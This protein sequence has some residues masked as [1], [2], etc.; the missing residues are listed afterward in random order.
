MIKSHASGADDMSIEEL[1]MF[2]DLSITLGVLLAFAISIYYIYRRIAKIA[3]RTKSKLDD[4]L[5]AVTK[6]PLALTISLF[7]ASYFLSYASKRL[8][9]LPFTHASD[10]LLQASVLVFM[11]SILVIIVQSIINRYARRVAS[12]EPDKETIIVGLQKFLTYLIWTLA[13]LAILSIIFPPSLPALLSAV[14]GVGFAAIVIGL[15]AQKVLGNWF[16][17]IIIF[18]SRPFRLGD[19]VLFRGD[20][21]MIEDIKLT[22]TIIKTW[23]NRRLVVPNSVFDSEVI[24]NYVIKDPRM[25]GMVFVDITYE[26]DYE[27]AKNLMIKIASEHPNV[28]PDMKPTVHLL[29]FGENGLKLRL[30]FMCKDQPTAFITAAE[31]R[32][33]IKKA[34][35]KNGIEIP[36]PRRYIITQDKERPKD[37]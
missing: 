26:S 27:L 17:G 28:L 36:Y 22:H 2:I 19:H 12:G 9:D 20:Y 37:K 15:A 18:L 13:I 32:E 7:I 1:G 5:V 16:S 3:A 10:R 25:I 31:L 8:P 23:D 34:F 35:D 4:Y 21:G 33:A 29:D 14:T 30:I 11:T 24:T 6:W